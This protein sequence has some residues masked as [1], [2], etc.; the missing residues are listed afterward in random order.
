MSY[1]PSKL[2]SEPWFMSLTTQAKLTY[3]YCASRPGINTLGL[4]ASTPEAM[5]SEIG[6]SKKDFD[7]AFMELYPLR[8]QVY[9]ISGVFWFL[10]RE[11]I[12]GFPNKGGRFETGVKQFYGLP[13]ELQRTLLKNYKLPPMRIVE[14]FQPPTP[15]EVTAYG[16]ELGYFIDGQEFVKF[17]SDRDWKDAKGK[18]VRNWK[19]KVKSVWAKPEKKIKAHK[20]A[21]EGFEHFFVMHNGRAIFPA[22]WKHGLPYGESLIEDSLLQNKYTEINEISN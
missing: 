11:Y 14:Q 19:L 15:E 5:A 7:Q 12:K 6:L 8:V 17:Y 9:E 2:W 3:I 21:P 16:I 10:V 22:E 13:D 18:K 4:F 20:D 1:S